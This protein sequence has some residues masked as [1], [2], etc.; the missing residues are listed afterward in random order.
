MR[1]ADGDYMVHLLVAFLR[2]TSTVL[3]Q[4]KVCFKPSQSMILVLIQYQ[5][6]G[7]S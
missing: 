2:D 6:M 5:R 1:R 3:D 4:K 7:T